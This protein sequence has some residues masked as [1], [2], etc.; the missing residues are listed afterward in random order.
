MKRDEH[1]NGEP[2][3]RKILNEQVH[4][5]CYKRYHH[6]RNTHVPENE[7]SSTTKRNYL[8]TRRLPFADRTNDQFSSSPSQ[9]TIS[10]TQYSKQNFVNEADL[11][12][13]SRDDNIR[14]AT[15][16]V[17]EYKMRYEK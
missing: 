9:T 14:S 17:S 11:R 7:Q 12:L 1:L 8:L 15:C 2:L 4:Q 3:L 6:H 16:H 5:K 13:A 10:N